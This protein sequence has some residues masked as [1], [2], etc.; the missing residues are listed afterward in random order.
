MNAMRVFLHDL[1]YTND[2]QGFLDRLNQH[3]TVSSSHGIKTILIIFD[4]VWNPYP[5]YGTQPV[6]VPGVHNSGW[7]QS[8][9]RT[10]L[11]DLA[12]HD[13]LEPYAK[14]V[15]S[16]FDGDDRVSA[17]EVLQRAGPKQ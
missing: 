15:F 10:I 6:P 5:V 11:G 4:D 8:P 2:K 9:G 16:T 3:L 12:A 13:N 7:L 17:F 1:L 14:W